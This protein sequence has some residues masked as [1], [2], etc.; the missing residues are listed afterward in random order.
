M[1][2]APLICVQDVP[3][4]SRWHQRLLGARGGHG[5]TSTSS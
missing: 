3:A 1:Q 4:S 2:L 5:G